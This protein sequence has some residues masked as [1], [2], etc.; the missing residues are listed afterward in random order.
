DRPRVQQLD[1]PV[2]RRP[3]ERCRLRASLHPP[4]A[5]DRRRLGT[6]LALPRPRLL[7]PP[8]RA[9]LWLRRPR[10]GAR[11]PLPR[12]RPGPGRDRRQR[13]PLPRD[14]REPRRRDSAD[15]SRPY[16]EPGWRTELIGP[17]VRAGAWLGQFAPPQVWRALSPPLVARLSSGQA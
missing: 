3:R 2:V 5:S 11:G 10:A 4:R 16:A 8:A 15:N 13:V 17:A 14:R 6:V 9:P 12:H 1:A 7:R